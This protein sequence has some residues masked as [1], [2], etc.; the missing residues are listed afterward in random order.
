MFRGQAKMSRVIETRREATGYE[1]PRSVEEALRALANGAYSILAG[2]T[3]YFPSQLE[4]KPSLPILDI[5]A[6]EELRGIK[7]GKEAW[8]IG[9]L[10]SWTEIS[11]AELPPAFDGLK[12][13][14]R[15]VGSVQIQNR[16]TIA[17]NLCNASPAADGVPPLLCL[18]AMI[19]LRSL[20]SARHLPLA[21][22]LQGYRATA[23]RPDELVSA[24]IVPKTSAVGSSGFLKLGA[25]RYLV[26]SI[27]MVAVRLLLDEAGRIEVARVAVG[28]CSPVARR[29]AVLESLLHGASAGPDLGRLVAEADLMPLAPIDDVRASAA[30]RMTAVRELVLRALREAMT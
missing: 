11:R 17:G 13:A 6:I 29:L 30:Y 16:A 2:G 23:R 21:D 1:R 9:A 15:E 26:I 5:T 14:A 3:D 28:A 22:F 25:R 24:I 27:A 18:D 12:L 8:R 20:N 19:E 7:A 4:G 10:T